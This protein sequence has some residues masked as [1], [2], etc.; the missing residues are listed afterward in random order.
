[1]SWHTLMGACL[2]MVLSVGC[3][4]SSDPGNDDDN[5]DD[6]DEASITSTYAEVT[7]IAKLIYDAVEAGEDVTPHL[8]GVFDAFDVPVLEVGDTAGAQA[9]IDAGLPFVTT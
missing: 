1:M 2:F 9:R 8:E 3:S 5:D 7:D 4:S 6:D